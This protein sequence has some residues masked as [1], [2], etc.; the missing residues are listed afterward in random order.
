ME[1]AAKLRVEKLSAWYGTVR[2]LDETSFEMRSNALCALIV[3][4][5]S[6]RSTLLRGLNRMIDTG[7][8]VRMS[9]R[10]IIDSEPQSARQASITRLRRRFL[11]TQQPNPFP[12]SVRTSSS[13]CPPTRR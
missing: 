11:V 10:V 9:G 2:A 5:G 8:G 12:K 1:P 4:S 3:P 7:R 6:G 13:A